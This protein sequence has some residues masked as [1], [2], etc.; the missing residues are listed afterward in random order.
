MSPVALAQFV[1]T[2]AIDLPVAQEPVP[3]AHYLRQPHRLVAAL[4]HESHIHP[5]ADDRYRLEMRP[6]N[7]MHLEFQ[8]TVDMRVWCEG[9]GTLRLRSLA[10]DIRGIEYINQRFALQLFGRLRPVAVDGM[11][12]LRGTADLGV[13]VELPPPL[14]F[15]PNSVIHSTGN[16]LLK[17][18]LQTIEQ[19]LRHSLLRDYGQWVNDAAVSSVNRPSAQR[20][21]ERS[22]WAIEASAP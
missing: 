1:A 2:Q 18:V 14:R 7:F 13:Q 5:L 16:R 17:G 11:T 20:P 21:E 22:V 19:R 4:A 9:D 8:P 12:H 6:L 3:I 15:I 10:C